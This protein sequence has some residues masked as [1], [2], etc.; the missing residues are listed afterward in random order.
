MWFIEVI[1]VEST[2]LICFQ[3]VHTGGGPRQ[4]LFTAKPQHDE[5]AGPAGHT[6]SDTAGEGEEEGGLKVGAYK[7]VC[8]EG[9]YLQPLQH[10]ESISYLNG[11]FLEKLYYS[12]HTRKE[13]SKGRHKFTTS[14]N[15]GQDDSASEQ[16]THFRFDGTSLED[17]SAYEYLL[18]PSQK[19]VCFAC[20]DLCKGS[21]WCTHIKPCSMVGDLA[22]RLPLVLLTLVST[23][24][25][26]CLLGLTIKFRH[27]KVSL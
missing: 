14:S 21:V 16:A 7:C 13:K 20:A 23:L 8:S 1:N 2:C 15:K 10:N 5:A 12:V 24:G 6:T 27:D 17:L 22:F 11:S 25:A 3:C 26:L 18:R 4:K 9:L 19:G